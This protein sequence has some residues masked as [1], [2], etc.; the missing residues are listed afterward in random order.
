MNDGIRYSFL[1]T[2]THS[3][4]KIYAECLP[5][6]GKHTRIPKVSSALRQPPTGGLRNRT[7]DCE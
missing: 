6:P 4:G 3:S 5:V 7:D 2:F 1:H